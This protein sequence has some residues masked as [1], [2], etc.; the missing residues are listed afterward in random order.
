MQSLACSA[1]VA[2]EPP[3]VDEA[4]LLTTAAG[5]TVA[6]GP[7]CLFQGSLTLRFGAVQ[8]L[9]LRQGEALLKLDAVARH[10]LT[11]ICLPVFA[12]GSAWTER[13][14]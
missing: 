13:A 12:V 8:A 6:I 10:E 2:L 14:G 4:M 3:A 7:T 11:G 5:A 9:K 1:L